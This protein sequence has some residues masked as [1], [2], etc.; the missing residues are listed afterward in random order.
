MS[1][2]LLVWL[3]LTGLS[4]LALGA[5]IVGLVRQA[6]VLMRSIGRFN[7]EVGPLASEIGRE[8]DRASQ[9]GASLQHQG[10][11]PRR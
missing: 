4:I 8:G 7:D 1:T 10:R 3:V 9:R 6:L 5:V 2:W 11:T